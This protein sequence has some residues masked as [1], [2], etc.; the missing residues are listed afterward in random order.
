MS[1]QE[2]IA[3]AKA[4]VKAKAEGKQIKAPCL[5]VWELGEVVFWI[6][7]LGTELN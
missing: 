3:L 7:N 5:K 1:T 2:I 4:I 6:E